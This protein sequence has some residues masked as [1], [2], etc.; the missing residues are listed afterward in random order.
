MQLTPNIPDVAVLGH[1]KSVQHAMVLTSDTSHPMFDT[2]EGSMWR[3]SKSRH[4]HC[5]GRGSSQ[6][7]FVSTAGMPKIVEQN[8]VSDP[9]WIRAS[10]LEAPSLLV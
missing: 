1:C 7:Q 3:S 9:D 6:A 2:L 5:D 8:G 10:V 4:L